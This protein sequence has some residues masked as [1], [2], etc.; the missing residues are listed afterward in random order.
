MFKYNPQSFLGL[1][2]G[3]LLCMGLGWYLKGFSSMGFGCGIGI[4]GTMLYLAA[5]SEPPDE[6]PPASL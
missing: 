4:I 3:S 6:T 2:W 1:F 5:V